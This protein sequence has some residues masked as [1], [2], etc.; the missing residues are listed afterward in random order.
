MSAEPPAVD[1]S[2][3][4][5]TP[6]TQQAAMPQ[7]RTLS[8][9]SRP[10][11]WERHSQQPLR[12]AP[13]DHRIRRGPSAACVLSEGL[14]KQCHGYRGDRLLKSHAHLQTSSGE[15]RRRM[16]KA[17]SGS[18]LRRREHNSLA[19]A[20]SAGDCP[21]GTL[22]SDTLSVHAT[23]SVEHHRGSPY[24]FSCLSPCC[25]MSCCNAVVIMGPVAVLC[26]S[27]ATPM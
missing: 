22:P 9:T 25:L 19:D 11:T 6:A 7:T 23:D 18:P 2:A 3:T 8:R 20:I 10:R 21:V 13:Q 27:P 17:S 12:T 26:F 4:D 24:M 16:R 1:G 15:D 5:S 14:P